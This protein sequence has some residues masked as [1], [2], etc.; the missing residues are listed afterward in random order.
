LQISE[1]R[2][3]NYILNKHTTRLPKVETACVYGNDSLFVVRKHGLFEY[4][5]SQGRDCTR[6]IE[7]NRQT[8][9]PRFSETSASKKSKMVAFSNGERMFVI[10]CNWDCKIYMGKFS[11]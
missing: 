5:F 3:P 7:N 1:E 10:I 4:P 2:E 6:R 8:L 11:M 9:E